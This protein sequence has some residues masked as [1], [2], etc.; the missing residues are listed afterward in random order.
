MAVNKHLMGIIGWRIWADS[1]PNK[2]STFS[3]TAMVRVAKSDA[4]D[5]M[6]SYQL[7]LSSKRAIVVD[8]YATSQRVLSVFSLQWNMVLSVAA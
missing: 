5:Y 3:F 6:G 7:R 2:G 1:M 4:R 8:G